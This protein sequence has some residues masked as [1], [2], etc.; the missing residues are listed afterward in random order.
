MIAVSAD[1]YEIKKNE[2]VVELRIVERDSELIHINLPVTSPEEADMICNH[3][4]EY[5]SD[6]YAYVISTLMAGIPPSKK[7]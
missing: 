1:Y 7:D 2:F 5:N 4:K 6:I 3:W